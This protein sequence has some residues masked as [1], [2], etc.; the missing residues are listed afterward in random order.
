MGRVSDPTHFATGL[1]EGQTYYWR[2]DDVEADGTTIHTGDLWSFWIPPKGA[3][4][5][6]PADGQA[7]TDTETDLIWAVDW[8]PVMY[9]VHFGTDADQVTNAPAGF[10]PPLMEVGFDPGPLEPGTTYY[11]R[12]DVFYGTWITGPVWSFSVSAAE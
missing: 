8:N 11:W 5:P 12:T 6:Q 2:I 1:V 3:Y 4:N 7:V 10:G 9:V